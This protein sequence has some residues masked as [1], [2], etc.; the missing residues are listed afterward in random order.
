MSRA[1]VVGVGR[2]VVNARWQLDALAGMSTPRRRVLIDVT[3]QDADELVAATNSCAGL[4]M[5]GV[6]RS[7]PLSQPAV[8]IALSH[9]N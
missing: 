8:N 1:T 2:F 4:N 3:D 6:H 9:T 7:L 5:I